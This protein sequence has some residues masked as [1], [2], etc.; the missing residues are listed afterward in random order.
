MGEI[1]TSMPTLRRLGL[2]FVPMLVA[3]TVVAEQKQGQTP[4]PTPPTSQQPS[5]FRTT[6]NGVTTPVIVR[7]KDGRF[8]PD[9]REDEFRVY[10]DD[11]LQAITIFSPWIGGRS[12]GNLATANTVSAPAGIPGLV[13][14]TSR[15]KSD[16]SGRLFVIFIDDLHF[17]ASETPQVR[18][19][20]K[21][22]RDLLVH[23]NDLVT[24]VS[25]GPSSVEIDLAY[26]Y[27]H[28]R[29][30]EAINK[31]IGSAPTMD[32][33]LDDVVSETAE[34]PQ[35]VR[36]NTHVAFQTAYGLLDQMAA[37]TDRRKAFV[38]LSDGY[39]FNPL[40]EGRLEAL[41]QHYGQYDADEPCDD[42]CTPSSDGTMPANKPRTS[43]GGTDTED[44][45]R[46][47]EYK[48]R[49]EFSFADLVGEVAALTRAAQRSNV[50]FYTVDPRGLIA[51]GDDAST[52]H[53]ISYGDLRDFYMTQISTLKTLAE[54]T[55]GF[56][57]VDTND[58][59]K[60]LRRI[61]A[62]TSDYYLLGYT[63]S[64]PDLYPLRRKIKVEVTRPG[65]E[66]ASYTPEYFL[67]KPKKK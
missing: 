18:A 62:E 7:D 47:N 41:Q 61:D 21:K 26:D 9:L 3:T 45:F 22:V 8:V 34:G 52:Q 38:F 1:V 6:S 46:E 53:K 13:L 40:E 19:V 58:F 31:V 37:I 36:Y 60:G 49:T 4:K 50:T 24:F 35:G 59:E 12:L 66:V 43:T 55:G 20:L 65:V 64:N 63:S 33:F 25:T 27:G 44:Q 56:A 14:P 32:N 11:V 16:S 57:L 30:D 51:G 67:P 28:R 39:N 17:T 5:V 42:S 48:K 23:D 10:E 15:P 2:I 29:F 54:Q